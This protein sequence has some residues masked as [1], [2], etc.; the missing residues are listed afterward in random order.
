[1]RIRQRTQ[2]ASLKIALQADIHPGA[3]P[4]PGCRDGLLSR[5]DPNQAAR[6]ASLHALLAGSPRAACCTRG[7]GA[8]P[9]AL[10]KGM[11]A[12]CAGAFSGRRGPAAGARLPAM[13]ASSRAPPDCGAAS[14]A[15]ACAA[16]ARNLAHSSSCS[17][18]A[19]A[20]TAPCPRV[21]GG[22]PSGG[23]AAAC[24]GPP[25]PACC[26][27]ASNLARSSPSSDGAAARPP[28]WPCGP[29]PAAPRCCVAESTS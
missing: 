3:G 21:S 22:L 17:D 9:G 14:S 11:K 7:P 25:S 13:P 12:A 6:C 28:P 19:P 20:R 16:R 27:R 29:A 4:L 23:A 2:R 18:G 26:A 5:S 24:A 8:M 10:G 15:S 1:M